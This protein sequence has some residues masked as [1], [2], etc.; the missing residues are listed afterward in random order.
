MSDQAGICTSQPQNWKMSNVRLL[1]HALHMCMYTYVRRWFVHTYIVSRVQNKDCKVRG[2]MTK[3]SS[4]LSVQQFAKVN[5]CFM[6]FVYKILIKWSEK[7]PN[8][9]E[10]VLKPILFGKWLMADC[11]F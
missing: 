5:D 7:G 9:F 8:T 11:Y 2:Q 10:S 3:T 6:E 1:F 4:S